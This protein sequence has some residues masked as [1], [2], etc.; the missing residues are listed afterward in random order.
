M[1]R[2]PAIDAAMGVK[3]QEAAQRLGSRRCAAAELG[4]SIGSVNRYFES[5]GE[6]A[7]PVMSSPARAAQRQAVIITADLWDTRRALE[8]NYARA[9]ALYEQLEAGL[10][11]EEHSGP[12]GPRVSQVP[13]GVHVAALKEIR[14]HIKVAVSISAQLLSMEAIQR[15]QAAV[16]EESGRA[17]EATRDRVVAALQRT[18]AVVGPALGPGG[19]EH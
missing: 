14:E 1:G 11:L 10:L 12:N 16:I 15:F 13:I 7:A 6:V 17:D 9:L 2:T 4:L 19:A 18:G 8:T 3:L 5:L